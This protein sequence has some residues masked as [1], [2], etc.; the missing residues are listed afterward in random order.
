MTEQDIDSG[1]TCQCC[2]QFVKRYSRKLN[3]SMALTLIEILKSGK[4]EFF[5]VE[6]FLK[7]IGRPELRADYH[8]LRFWGFLEKQIGERL[9]GSPRN[10]FYKITGRGIAFAENKITAPK[11]A[12]ILNNELHG[13][14]GEDVTISQC[15]RFNYSELMGIQSSGA[16]TDSELKKQ[17][18]K[19]NDLFSTVHE[20]Y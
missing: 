8:K 19:Q 12:L 10:G 15:T 11:K 13:F 17:K 9:D 1:Y 6:N 3:S 18:A 20:N 16:K 7:Q 4:R 14:E 2:G 5:H